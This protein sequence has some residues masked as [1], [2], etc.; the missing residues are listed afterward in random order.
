MIKTVIFD[1]GGTLLGA[2][3]LFHMMAEQFYENEGNK[4]TLYDSLKMN[5]MTQY[6]SMSADLAEFKS[7]VETICCTLA[8]IFPNFMLSDIKNKAKQIQYDTFLYK[9][10][11]YGDTIE[12]LDYLQNRQIELLVA[13]DAD[14]EILHLELEKYNLTK[15]FC[16]LFISEELRAYKPSWRFVESI[17]SQ[18][19]FKPNETI[20]IG[21]SDVDILTGKRL[22][23]YTVLKSDTKKGDIDA[24]YVIP[25]LK[26]LLRIIE[27]IDMES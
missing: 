5:F 3:D 10:F 17:K 9:S 1:I 2:P 12:T 18:L 23:V 19:S 16:K 25:N 15:Y 24:D 13:S 11:I 4:N 22:G 14:S 27:E 7:L 6:K 26:Q 8:D 21:D 20:F